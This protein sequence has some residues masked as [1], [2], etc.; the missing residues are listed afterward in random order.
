[1]K[2]LFKLAVSLLICGLM[3]LSGCGTTSST[4]LPDELRASNSGYP[5][6]INI[7]AP[8]FFKFTG[9]PNAEEAKQKWLGEMS[10]RYSV[11]FN[12]FRD[13]GEANKSGNG[14]SSLRTVNESSVPYLPNSYLPLDDYLADNPVWNSL[15]E[16]FK[17]LFEV[18]GHIYAI[19]ASVSEGVQKARVFNNE[20]L[21]KTG[22]TVTD[23]KSFLAFAEAYRKK[24]GNPANSS[25]I[26]DIADI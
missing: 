9:A 10:E 7:I 13:Y 6:S 18:D 5:K 8:D 17:T 16:D 12:V 24:T 2:K 4:S 22:V 14:P 1:M 15:P 25:L 23:L 19:P 11:S 21:Q 26:S 3:L 20:A